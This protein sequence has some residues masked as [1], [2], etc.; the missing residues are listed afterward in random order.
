M[1]DNGHKLL[2]FASEAETDSTDT[3]RSQASSRGGGGGYRPRAPANSL[4]TAGLNAGMS[5]GGTTPDRPIAVCSRRRDDACKKYFRR[6]LGSLTVVNFSVACATLALR[7]SA[8]ADPDIRSDDI[9]VVD[10]EGIV[11][12]ACKFFTIWMIPDAAP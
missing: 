9:A 10:R 6:R 3:V 5:S 8:Q 12:A 4:I 1:V 11:T 7:L 2:S